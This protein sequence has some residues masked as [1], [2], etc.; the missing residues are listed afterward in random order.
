MRHL[1]L[2]CPTNTK[3]R[4][5][6][7]EFMREALAYAD[8]YIDQGDTCEVHP[9]PYHRARKGRTLMRKVVQESFAGP[10]HQYGAIAIFCHG[11][12]NGIQMGYRVSDGTIKELAQEIE[13]AC[14]ADVIVTLY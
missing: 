6:G 9:I 12:S 10:M 3:G 5:D 2:Y 1:V 13:F 8:H 14:T 11:W 7:D 4:H